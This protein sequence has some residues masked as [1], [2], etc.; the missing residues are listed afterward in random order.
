METRPSGHL[1]ID[2]DGRSS[3]LESVVWGPSPAI[4]A[5]RRTLTDTASTDI[6][7]LLIGESGTGKEALA[8]HAHHLSGRREPLLRVNC[9]SLSRSSLSFANGNGNGSDA[10]QG[11]TILLDNICELDS[12]GQ[13]ILL[14]LLSEESIGSESHGA[15]TRVI[16]TASRRLEEDLQSGKFISELY[17]RLN[18]VCLLIPPLR[19]RREDIPE[20][21]DFF[22]TKYGDQFA[23]RRPELDSHILRRLV[24]YSWPGNVRQLE[25][26]IKRI[27]ATGEPETAVADLVEIS[28]EPRQPSPN[29]SVSLK[30]AAR[31]ASRQTERELLSQAL[32]RTHWNRKRAARELQISYKALLYKLKQLGLDSS[33]NS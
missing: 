18:G 28:R 6:P 11:G 24:G 22:L 25:N 5:V 30:I 1:A 13:R 9:R 31:E 2:G 14:E 17:F 33:D 26:T 4:Q 20:F 21:V 29:S 23:K 10:V 3:V 16:S 8:F 27:V 7:I 32:A 15:G 12:S 19:K